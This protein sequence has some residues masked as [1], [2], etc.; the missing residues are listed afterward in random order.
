MS[1]VTD[2][3]YYK[4]RKKGKAGNTRWVLFI[5]FL[6]TCAV[7]GYF[8]ALSPFFFIDDIEVT[9]NNTVDVATLLDLSG[10]S[11]GENIFTVD[12]YKT[13]QMIL[14]DPMIRDCEIERKLPGIISINVAE[15]EA[16]AVI[17]TGNGFLY[18]DTD[19][20]V[21]SRYREVT[22]IPLPILVGIGDFLPGSVPGTRI[23]ADRISTALNIVAAVPEEAQYVF[24]E[25]NV[26]D[27]QKIVTYVHDGIRAMIGDKENISSKVQLIE[28]ILEEIENKGKSDSIQYIDVSIIEK[29]VIYYK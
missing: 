18:V 6:F 3:N 5:V 17:P 27:E 19:G 1:K 22:E 7:G 11:K 28:K 24:E 13:K 8:F 26:S 10:V 21:L 23:D 16:V 29:P 25:I 12:L 15:R 20:V 9:G 4:R 14:I 2:I